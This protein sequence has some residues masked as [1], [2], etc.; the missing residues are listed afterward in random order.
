VDVTLHTERKCRVAH[1]TKDTEVQCTKAPSDTM[2][3]VKFQILE[4]SSGIMAVS[5][6]SDRGLHFK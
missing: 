2:I 5:N 6:V 4:I 1:T 3:V